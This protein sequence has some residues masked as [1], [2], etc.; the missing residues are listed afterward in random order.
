MRRLYRSRKN[1]KL[2]GIFGGLGEILS[3]DPTILRLAYVFLV[4]V[5]I[6][7]WVLP[8]IP[9]LVAYIVGWV[10]IPEGE[11]ET[12]GEQPQ[13]TKEKGVDL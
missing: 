12:R 7:S 10:I 9:I 1:R 6:F 5:A 8:A 13:E 4:L 3:I 2:A 11:K